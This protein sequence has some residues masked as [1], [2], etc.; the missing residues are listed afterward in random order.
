MSRPYRKIQTRYVRF[1]SSLCRLFGCI[2]TVFTRAASAILSPSGDNNDI[3]VTAKATG[4][5]GN[6]LTAAVVIAS[7]GNA[8]SVTETDRKSVV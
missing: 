7:G 3:L 8:L 4:T 5:A 6:S 2:P 1:R